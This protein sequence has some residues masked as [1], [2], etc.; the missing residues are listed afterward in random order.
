[1]ESTEF[2]INDYL[3][4]ELWGGKTFIYVNGK[5]FK[6]CKYVLLNI[7]IDDIDQYSSIKSIDEVIDNLDHS[8]EDDEEILTPEVEFWAHCSNLQAWAETSYNT[9]LLDSILSFPLLK[10]L[11]E[12]GDPQAKRV[13]REEI[14]KRL[15]RGDINTTGYLIDDGYLEFLT[16]EELNSIF[17]SEECQLFENIFNTFKT[18]DMDQFSAAESIYNDISKYLFGS[19]ERKLQQIFDTKSLEDIYTFFNCMMLDALSDEEILLLFDPPMNLL[20]RTLSFLK[21]INYKEIKIEE[22]GLF[23]ERVENVL[24]DKIK[25]KILGILS[26][27]DLKYFGLWRLNLLKHLESEDS[28]Y[29]DYLK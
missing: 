19:I 11:T 1:M 13:F 23:S 22:Y 9:D 12:E 2:K 10:K 5:K 24:G 18:G 27:G 29:L 14:A 28:D 17:S 15:M 25:E 8:L 4:L 3:S 21:N 26:R 6:Q 16:C 20:E 7:P